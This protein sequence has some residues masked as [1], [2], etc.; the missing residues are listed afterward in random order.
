M[1]TIT[2]EYQKLRVSQ[3]PPI[4]RV[5]HE[6]WIRWRAVSDRVA[7][8]QDYRVNGNPVSKALLIKLMW[9]ARDMMAHHNTLCWQYEANQ[10]P[11]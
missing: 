3:L 5:Q 7:N 11:Q 1:Y 8:H 6:A 9:F 4:A 2:A 10:S